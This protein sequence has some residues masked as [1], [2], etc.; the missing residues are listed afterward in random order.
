MARSMK[1]DEDLLVTIVTDS[2]RYEC[3]VTII[4]SHSKTRYF[5]TVHDILCKIVSVFLVRY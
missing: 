5:T 4:T 1:Q 3:N 2:T